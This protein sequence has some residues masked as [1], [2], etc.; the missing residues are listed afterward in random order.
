MFCFQLVELNTFA[1]LCQLLGGVN[2]TVAALIVA[3]TTTIYTAYG[4]FKASFRTGGGE[5]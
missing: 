2:P 1:A 5:L 4:G 3:I